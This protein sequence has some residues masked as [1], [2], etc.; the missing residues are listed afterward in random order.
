MYTIQICLNY[1]R[2]APLP[3]LQNGKKI[4]FTMVKATDLVI[5]VKLVP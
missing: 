2:I 4:T 5:P 1:P 3:G